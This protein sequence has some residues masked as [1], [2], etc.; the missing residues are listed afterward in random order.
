MISLILLIAFVKISI[1][2]NNPLVLAGAY[3]V[4]T[5]LISAMFTAEIAVVMVSAIITFGLTWVFFWLLDRFEDSGVWWV[6][7][8]VFPLLILVLSFGQ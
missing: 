2:Y 7:V 3:T 1:H 8:T 5:T 4:L 6:L